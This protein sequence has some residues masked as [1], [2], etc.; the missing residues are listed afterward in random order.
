[1]CFNKFNFICNI[2]DIYN[3]FIYDFDIFVRFPGGSDDKESAY[4]SGDPG[5]IR[6]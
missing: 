1:M 3:Q 4:N 5:S 2:Y 6:G